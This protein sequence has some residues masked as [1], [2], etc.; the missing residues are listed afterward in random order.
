MRMMYARV[1]A[2]SRICAVKPA[3]AIVLSIPTRAE[4]KSSSEVLLCAR[5][6]APITYNMLERLE[7]QLDIA[8]CVGVD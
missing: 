3:A 5:V 8:V 7:P 1:A 2:Q 6:K 4:S